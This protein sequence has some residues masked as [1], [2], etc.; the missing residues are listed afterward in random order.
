MSLFNG[1]NRGE[2]VDVHGGVSSGGIDQTAHLGATGRAG[3]FRPSSPSEGG[4]GS[5]G[6]PLCDDIVGLFDADRIYLPQNLESAKVIRS[7]G[8]FA[9]VLPQGARSLDES[10]LKSVAGKPFVVLPAFGTEGDRFSREVTER[11]AQFDPEN[12][13]RIVRF[14]ELTQE[15]DD[16][17]KWIELKKG[18][19]PE[20]IL[21]ELEDIVHETAPWEPDTGDD[22]DDADDE[23][24]TAQ[25]AVD[26]SSLG[27]KRS[28]Q[29]EILLE[30]AQSAS[31]FHTPEKKAYGTIRTHKSGNPTGGRIEHV[32][33]RHEDFERWLTH[34]YY[35]ERGSAPPKDVIEN[36]IKAL[37]ARA[38]FDGPTEQVHIRVASAPGPAGL[39]YY[40]DLADEQG[41]AVEINSYEWGVVNDPPVK[42]RR[43]KTMRPLP[44]PVRGG[45]L[46]SLRQFVNI[47]SENDWRLFL[48]VLCA[49]LRPTGPYPLLVIQ[50]EQGSA[51]STTTRMVSQ[52]IDPIAFSR[53]M[54]RDVH[55]LSIAANNSWVLTMDNLSGLAP[56]L[57]DALCRLATGGGFATRTLYS[58]DEETIF[59]AMRPIVL[60][61][62]D[63]IAERPDLLDRSIVLNLPR[64]TGAQR[65]TETELEDL[66]TRE[67]PKILG[68]LLDA[69]SGGLDKYDE[70]KL[71][72]LPRMADF[73]RFGEAVFRFL[74]YG[75]GEFVKAL[76]S[77]Q[78]SANVSVL[79]ACPVAA[80]VL[81]LMTKV[82]EWQGTATELLAHLNTTVD[83]QTMRNGDWPKRPNKLSGKLRRIAP[84]LRKE[85][86]EV[87]LTTSGKQRSIMIWRSPTYDA[88][89][90]S[91]ASSVSSEKEDKL[92]VTESYLS[93]NE[94]EVRGSSASGAYPRSSSATGAAP[95]F[96][97]VDPPCRVSGEGKANIDGSDDLDDKSR[98]F[99]STPPVTLENVEADDECP[100]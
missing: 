78:N 98:Y 40:L 18:R 47:G 27:S 45:T 67:S 96:P 38:Q 72:R 7:L 39:T 15:G 60:N 91:S 19:S 52:L 48:A 43:P 62:I 12:P 30:L 29:V 44:V 57:S 10:F 33:L 58:N 49:Y 94:P 31:L 36:A 85:E 92:L 17:T 54:P 73:A 93:R 6:S 89:N 23:Q 90:L 22:S 14:R 11:L 28:S 26:R 34:R 8:E 5:S 63:D 83:E 81:Q 75:Q 3:Q 55:S 53:S 13:V 59:A 86:V 46:D 4:Y 2:G 74:G 84:V 64:L 77:N 70:V 20:E 1:R 80:A 68:A 51:K 65:L 88:S 25:R 35:R 37:E 50:G 66:F 56:W 79:E 82:P 76:E 100:F 95:Q 97:N 9:L 99:P 61:G 21:V 16:I 69:V 71:D 42:F 41:R 24:A 87:E 32:P